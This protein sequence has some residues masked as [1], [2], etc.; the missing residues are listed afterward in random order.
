MTKEIDSF[1]VLEEKI[2]Q[3]V[4]DYSSLKTGKTALAEK[5]AQ[6][7]TELKGLKEEVD[8][9]TAE[10]EAVKKKVENLLSRIDR[11]LPPGKQD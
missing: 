6:K 2:S 4:E 3:L 7:E 5:L 11:I 10:R 8:F 1:G 9:L